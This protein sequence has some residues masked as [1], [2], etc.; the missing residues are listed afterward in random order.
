LLDSLRFDQIDDRFVNIQPGL[1]KTCKWL[2]QSTEYLDWLDPDKVSDHH[3]FFWIKG[4]PGSGKSTLTKFAFVDA[5]KAHPSSTILSFFFNARGTGLEKSTTGLYRSLLVQLLGECTGYEQALH[6]P[7]MPSQALEERLKTNREMLKNLLA[8]AIQTI[9]Q[10]DIMIIIDALDECDEDEVREMVDFFEILGEDAVSNGRQLHVLF[11]SRHYPYVKIQ[12]CV[13]IILEDQQGHL[14]DIEK[15]VT[16][17]LRA[18]KGKQGQQIRKDIVDRASGIFI[19]VVL[20]VQ[21][22]N[23]ELDHG[24][25]HSLR[26]KLQ[27]IPKDLNELFRRIL[28]RDTQYMGQMKLC[29]QW[30]LYARRPMKREEIYFAI[31]SGIEPEKNF[32]WDSDDISTETM[33]RFILSSSKGLAEVTKSKVPTVQFI[34]ETVRDFL[35]KE[36]GLGQRWE[37]LKI[38]TVGLSHNH[39]RDCCVNYTRSI[40][41]TYITAQDLDRGPIQAKNE[42]ANIRQDISLKYPFL[43]YVMDN[44]LNHADSAH[45]KG[46]SQESFIQEFDLRA[47]VNLQNIVEKYQLRRFPPDID[48][49]TVL[50]ARNCPNLIGITPKG[51]QGVGN[52]KGRFENPFVAAIAHD[53]YEAVE[54]LIQSHREMNP[55]QGQF[56]LPTD[57]IATTLIKHA[58]PALA[59]R[60]LSVYQQEVPL[61][62]VIHRT[63]LWFAVKAGH[64]QLVKLLLDMSKKNSHDDKVAYG[65]MLGVSASIGHARIVEYLL[66]AGVKVDAHEEGS[67]TALYYASTNGHTQVVKLLL[68]ADANAN[69]PC[70]DCGTALQAASTRKNSAEIIKL[71]LH[72]GA[73]VNQK[74]GIYGNALQAALA[75]DKD[76]EVVK[77]LLEA[78]ADVHAQGGY[79]GNALQAASIRRNGS[80]AELLVCMGADVKAQGGYYG[81][82]LQAAIFTGLKD[83]IKLLLDQGADVKAQGGFYGNALQAASFGGLEGIVK[84]V[85]DQG[86]DV[87]AEGGYWGNPLQAATAKGNEGIVKLLL[88]KGADVNATG[89]EYGSALGALSS[90]MVREDAKKIIKKLLLDRGA[91]LA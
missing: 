20:V 79:Y 52:R 74:G 23:K 51:W 36:N 77:L 83:I 27:E 82:A 12:R 43:G 62:K 47:W 14:Q 16:G 81:N 54:A 42:A 6:F 71:L 70:G 3:G 58:K 91:K 41:T 88:D 25:V 19:W 73:D 29:L 9:D 69:I 37:D 30:V 87:N 50:A 60:F 35:L 28:T 90:P 7:R 80:F 84:L 86:A 59:Y 11:S 40:I 15:Y 61:T 2:I 31:L 10:H 68:E 89:G 78:G 85:L 17:K 76:E 75:S 53:N 13:E 65:N 55:G 72:R 24:R 5:K 44:M 1:A 32:L 57:S 38:N 49:S 34:H 63:L 4:K 48:L 45:A 21:I 67:A 33:D 18:S 39:L 26:K 46:I 64:G 8:N 56:P 66:E 22:I